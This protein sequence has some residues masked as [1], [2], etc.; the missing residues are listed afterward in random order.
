MK[1]I[2]VDQPGLLTTVQDLGRPGFGPIGVSASGAA[3]PISLRLGNRL[4]GNPDNAP[5]LETT[6]TGGTFNFPEGA[7]V[8]L[9]GSDFG[10]ALNSAPVALWTALKISPGQTLQLNASRS[11]ARCYLCVHG[12]ISVPPILSSASTHL[13]SGLGGF[14]GRALRKGDVLQ[15]GPTAIEPFHQRKIEP[16]KIEPL[17]TRTVLRVTP[18]P[19]AGWFRESS[20]RSFY[21]ET[22]R[23]GEQSNRMGLRLEGVKLP[24]CSTA[25]MIT[26]GV[27][28]GAIQVPAGG[29]PIVLSVEQQT[30]GG[31]PK[32][33][34]VISADLH[35]LGQLRPR[36]EIRFE[37]VS[38]EMGRSLLLEQER[39]LASPE[40][41]SE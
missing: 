16:R 4:V 1:T 25:A 35:R 37:Q 14:E 38:F 29:A 31:Y 9:T 33:A 32:I 20:I 22:Y 6:L 30:T 12:G 11:G 26:E 28:L 7:V 41:I 8:A 5:G 24:Q 27:S 15:I 39:L 18:G 17:L 34:N 13:L 3:D 10:A 21:S 19:Q 40:M 2:L 23:V 36:D